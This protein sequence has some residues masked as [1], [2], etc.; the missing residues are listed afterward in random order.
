MTNTIRLSLAL[1]ALP[2]ASIPPYALAETAGQP[3]RYQGVCDYNPAIVQKFPTT[4]GFVR[5]DALSISRSNGQSVISYERTPQG[6]RIAFHG[7]LEGD[8]MAISRV[9]LD[10]RMLDG[11]G[12]CTIYRDGDGLV[13]IVT[14]IGQAGQTPLAANFRV[15][16]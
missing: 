12:K 5:C 4:D 1:M 7:K 11:R 14:C 15:L 13:S 10:D 3:I 6:K 8:H 9:W 16:R 2:M